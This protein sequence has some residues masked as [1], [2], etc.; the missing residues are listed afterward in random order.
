MKRE[1]LDVQQALQRAKGLPYAWI[2]RLSQVY[3]GYCPAEISL[4]EL[5]EARF[6]GPEE[7]VRLFFREGQLQAAVCIEEPGDRVIPATY[8]LQHP[9]QFGQELTVHQMVESDEDGQCY[10]AAVRLAEWK[11][12]AGDE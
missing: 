2:C 1:Q 11:G 10:V 8:A 5:L 9:E 6:F 4:E 3:L 12:G 7:E